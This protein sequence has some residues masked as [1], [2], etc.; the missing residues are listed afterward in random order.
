MSEIALRISP[1]TKVHSLSLVCWMKSELEGF[2]TSTQRES[3]SKMFV[4]RLC[5]WKKLIDRNEILLGAQSYSLGHTETSQLTRRF[6]LAASPGSQTFG[7]KSRRS[8]TRRDGDTQQTALRYIEP[9]VH[10]LSTSTT[11]SELRDET[12]LPRSRNSTSQKRIFWLP[13]SPIARA[14]GTLQAIETAAQTL[15]RHNEG[16]SQLSRNTKCDSKA[17]SGSHSRRNPRRQRKG[18]LVAG[19]L[20]YFIPLNERAL[21]TRVVALLREERRRRCA[22]QNFECDNEDSP[23]SDHPVEPSSRES[24]SRGEISTWSHLDR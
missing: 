4:S 5:P 12:R 6:N 9:F 2:R 16:L 13:Q 11:C 14:Q 19:A 1:T 20:C 17:V 7:E 15:F 21:S 22:L 24:V 23:K 3:C 10:A 18:T 8:F